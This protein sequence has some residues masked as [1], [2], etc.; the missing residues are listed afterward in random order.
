MTGWSQIHVLSKQPG[1]SSD[2]LP[3]SQQP[4]VTVKYVRLFTQ[5]VVTVSSLFSWS[6]FT[7]TLPHV[8]SLWIDH[9]ILPSPMVL[10]RMRIDPW[11]TLHQTV[12]RDY[13]SSVHECH[14][15]ERNSRQESQHLHSLLENDKLFRSREKFAPKLSFTFNDACHCLHEFMFI[16]VKSE[17]ISI[18]HWSCFNFSAV[19]CMGNLHSIWLCSPRFSYM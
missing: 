19:T 14:T 10:W 1:F 15:V 8:L 7:S 16:N 3:E 9:G 13:L 5:S 2:F 18:L 6:S 4:I 11:S 17:I 12:R